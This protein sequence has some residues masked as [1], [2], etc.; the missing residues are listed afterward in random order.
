[1]RQSQACKMQSDQ[2]IPQNKG[3]KYMSHEI[4]KPIDRVLSTTG[5]E[6]HGLAEIREVIN[7]ETL[8]KDGVLFPITKSQVIN[9]HGEKTLQ[10]VIQEVSNTIAAAGTKKADIAK[11]FEAMVQDLSFV[12]THQTVI[13]DLTEC[14][15]DL[16]EM[17]IETRIPLG[18]PKS[19]YEIITNEEAFDVIGRVF[20]DCKVVTAGTL[21]GA[22][23][24]FFSLDL[25][26]QTEYT[27]PR[28]DKYQQYLDVITSHDGTLGFRVYD[29]G[30]RIVCMNTL[31]ASLSG[32]G[33]IDMVV[34][35]S[36]N[37]ANA[38]N[39]VSVNLQ[40]IFEGRKAY[41]NSLEYLESVSRTPEQVR[42]ITASFL[43]N[44]PVKKGGVPNESI[45][46]Q[47]FNKCEEVAD[48]FKA[49]AGNRGATD[50]DFLNG[51]TECWTWGSGTGAK[52]SKQEKF[53]TSRDGTASEI[54]EEFF[55]FLMSGTDILERAAAEGEKLY[56]DKELLLAA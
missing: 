2:T 4:E 6:W 21:R 54:K 48:L 50:Y 36:K 49:G 1:M 52:A 37:A 5:P 26:G 16:V 47:I 13:A 45:S 31:K 43:N 40:D 10:E 8:R 18:I 3:I 38:L 17:G 42:Y 12:G 30:T 29:S 23:V 24:L 11:V 55:N 20:P 53:L 25:D 35:H 28:G 34:Y 39:R 14:R 7:K 33:D 15:P 46:T 27:G 32:K 9:H 22:K 51:V 56:K 44:R 19:S 41:F